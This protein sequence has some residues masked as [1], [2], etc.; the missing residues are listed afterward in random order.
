M[1]KSILPPVGESVSVV[2]HV[3]LEKMYKILGNIFH[4]YF[5][6]LNH[7]NLSAL[8]LK[9]EACYLLC[10]DS[11]LLKCCC[12]QLS[13]KKKQTRLRSQWHTIAISPCSVL[14]LLLVWQMDGKMDGWKNNVALA[15]LYHVGKSCS[16]KYLGI[17]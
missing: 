3:S 17:L 14:I 11:G 15:H 6:I 5:T 1:T 4:L 9:H 16:N 8:A 10:C 13:K 2:F 12:R 7:H